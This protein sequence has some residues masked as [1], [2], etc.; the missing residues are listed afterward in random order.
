V[1]HSSIEV[2]PWLS[3]ICKTSKVKSKTDV[4]GVSVTMDVRSVEYI[5]LA[6]TV[7]YLTFDLNI[8][9]FLQKE[10]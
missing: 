5:A 1:C 9:T 2:I 3:L 8:L 7:A 10:N 4:S 6:S